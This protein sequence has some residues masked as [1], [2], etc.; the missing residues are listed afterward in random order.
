ME[1]VRGDGGWNPWK[2]NLKNDTKE[3]GGVVC[4]SSRENCSE[5]LSIIP[6]QT[7]VTRQVY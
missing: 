7:P 1:F 5:M 4:K 2:N 3:T 6:M